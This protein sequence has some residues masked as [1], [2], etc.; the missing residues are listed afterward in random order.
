MSC[1][2]AVS[3]KRKIYCIWYRAMLVQSGSPEFPKE[4][5]DN[6]TPVKGKALIDI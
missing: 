2:T 6:L 5:V 4:D 1:G 3:L